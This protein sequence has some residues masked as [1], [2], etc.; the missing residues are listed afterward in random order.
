MC[1]CY[2][3]AFCSPPCF[4]MSFE[5]CCGVR[6]GMSCKTMATMHPETTR[7]INKNPYKIKHYAFKEPNP[8]NFSTFAMVC[9]PM[10]A[11]FHGLNTEF[12][13]AS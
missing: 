9:T 11:S 7:K 6:I 8:A 13:H 4:K 3:S 2:L 5:T 1:V 10:N 12:H